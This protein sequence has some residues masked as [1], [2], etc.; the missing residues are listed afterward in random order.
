MMQDQSIPQHS[1]K[2]FSWIFLHNLNCPPLLHYELAIYSRNLILEHMKGPV[3]RA[4]PY[5]SYASD[6]Q[7]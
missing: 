4:I 3:S 2:C 6:L 7:W 1:Y 5:T